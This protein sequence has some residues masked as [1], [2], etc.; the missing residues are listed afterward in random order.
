[1]LPPYYGARVRTGA[2]QVNEAGMATRQSELP[3]QDIELGEWLEAAR[4]PHR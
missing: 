2:T 1:M 4:L 3:D